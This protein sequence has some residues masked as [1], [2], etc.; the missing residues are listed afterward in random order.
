MPNY[1]KEVLTPDTTEEVAIPGEIFISPDTA[2]PN[3]IVRHAMTHACIP[4]EETVLPEPLPF[5]DGLIIGY[6]GLSLKALLNSGEETY[7]RLFEEGMAERNA[8]VLGDYQV[9]NQ[10]YF[11]IGKLTLQLFPLDNM[12]ADEYAENND[13]PGFVRAILGLPQDAEVSAEQL[14]RVMGAYQKVWD[15]GFDSGK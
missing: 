10:K 9:E 5:S 12:L 2:D 6:H 7:F 11:D 1:L 13:V 8:A 14:E 4:E 3:D 15:T